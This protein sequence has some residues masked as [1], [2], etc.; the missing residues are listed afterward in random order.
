VKIDL[1]VIEAGQDGII[2]GYSEKPEKSY[3]VSMGIYVYEPTVL[4]YV[5]PNKYLDFPTLALRIIDN[6]EKVAGYPCD[7]YWMDIGC[8]EDYIRAQEVFEEKKNFY[9]IANKTHILSKGD[10]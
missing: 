1:G 4:Q 5:S 9:L 7:D 2:T 3:L 10:V 8:Q 6:E